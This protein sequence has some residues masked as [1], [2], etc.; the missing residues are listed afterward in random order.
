VE[1]AHAVPFSPAISSSS[2]R[3]P[4]TR[5][6]GR[7]VEAPVDSRVETLAQPR[8][9]WSSGGVYRV[10]GT[11]STEPSPGVPPWSLVLKI[12][13]PPTAPSSNRSFV[14]STWTDPLAYHYW[15]REPL[16]YRSGLLDR[17][18]GVSAPRSLGA[19]D[20]E[21]GSTWL[22]LEDVPD[23]A[24]GPWPL[25][26]FGDAARALGR[27]N[28]SYLVNQPLPGSGAHPWLA[29][30]GLRRMAE[31]HA[32]RIARARH[33]DV[34]ST[35]HHPL[36]RH[37]TPRPVADELMQL[38]DAREQLF[39]MLA[40]LPQTLCHSDAWRRNVHTSRA[41]ASVAHPVVSAAGAAA[42]RFTLIDWAYTGI[43]AVGEEIGQLV[44]CAL[45][46]VSRRDPVAVTLDEAYALDRVVFPAYVE[47]LRA[48]GWEGD[49]RL[50][51]QGYTASAVRW[52]FHAGT[53]NVLTAAD[54]QQLANVE[55]RY[56]RPAEATFA[57][58]G[59]TTIYLLDLAHEARELAARSAH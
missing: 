40:A 28:A 20:R 18:Q 23:Q 13:R 55:Q 53:W 17:L 35:W 36:V 48:G 59:A 7:D 34:A 12:C 2:L 21:D 49:E 50:I 1:A 44:A 33:A 19:E 14:A 58:S 8:P 16:A 43:G 54:P 37:A 56:G 29:R 32:A 26:R 22:W 38:W 45:G 30:H 11:G 51:R 3:G 10:S 41:T 47:G 42:E 9:E 6:L 46:G 25:T 15:A 39:A 4:L 31:A 5:L 52:V 27:F 24:E 57:Q